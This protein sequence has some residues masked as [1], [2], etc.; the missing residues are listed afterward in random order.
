MERTIN[1]LKRVSVSRRN[2]PPPG[3]PPNRATSTIA[4]QVIPVATAMATSDVTGNFIRMWATESMMTPV[5]VPGLAAK[6]IS[7]VSDCMD[8]ASTA[9]GCPLS[10]EN[11]IHASTPPPAT[12]KA[13]SD[14]PKE[15]QQLH[16]EQGGEREDDEN[17]GA[18]LGGD[19]H[20]LAQ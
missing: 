7:G 20:L 17:G 18:C 14:T 1:P 12:M 13:S 15:V 9:A 16:P 6:R 4:S 11:P 5:I 3:L 2:P 10:M 19:G 8:F